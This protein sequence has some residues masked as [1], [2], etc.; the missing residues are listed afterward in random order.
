MEEY[1]RKS[2][3]TDRG[4]FKNRAETQAQEIIQNKQNYNPQMY[5]FGLEREYYLIDK[6]NYL[7]QRDEDTCDR[8]QCQHELGL[9]NV[10]LACN[11]ISDF[12]NLDNFRYQLRDEVDKIRDVAGNRRVVLDGCVAA[13]EKGKTIQEYMKCSEDFERYNIP[14]NM[15]KDIYYG[16]LDY[17]ISNYGDATIKH[18]N[19]THNAEGIMP[20]SL[21]CSI[22][23]HIQIPEVEK[24][25]QYFA[26]SIRACAPLLSVSTNSP[27][28]PPTMYDEKP[29][30]KPYTHSL[31]IQI[32]EQLLNQKDRNGIRIPKDVDSFEELINK[33]ASHSLYMPLL[34]EDAPQVDWAGNSYEFNHQQRTCWWWVNPR[35]GSSANGDGNAVRIELRPFPNQP[36]FQDNISLFCACAGAIIGIVEE[37]HP[38]IDLDWGI[39][40]DN[41]RQAERNGPNADLNWINRNGDRISDNKQILEDVMETARKGLIK[42]GMSEEEANGSLRYIEK[43]G[44]YSPSQWK[45]DIYNQNLEN[46][47]YEQALRKVFLQYVDNMKRGRSFYKW[48]S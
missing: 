7:A 9:H 16:L 21:T 35:V 26:A 28:L 46:E 14:S 37:E 29:D 40:R 44:I 17:D 24:V 48:D 5:A 42:L 3:N 15:T 12:S 41:L 38:V 19:F 10:E 22:Q 27:Y 30:K 31:R 43:R 11:P 8:A 6:A 39:A 2:N 33:I 25:P 18:P 32:Q 4:E 47:Q 23:P 45:A 36:T 13:S 34:S 20:I 1:I